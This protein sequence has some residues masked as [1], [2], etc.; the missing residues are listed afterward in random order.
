[1][2]PLTTVPPLW[3]T[4]EGPKTQTTVSRV[5]KT[6]KL[7]KTLVSAGTTKWGSASTG[8][9]EKAR[10]APVHTPTRKSAPGS[11]LADQLHW[12]ADGRDAKRCTQSPARPGKRAQPALMQTVK[13]ST[14]WSQVT[15]ESS[16][17]KEPR[18]MA[19]PK[20]P[21]PTPGWPK[22]HHNNNQLLQ[23][24]SFLQLPLHPSQQLSSSSR[25]RGLED[26]TCRLF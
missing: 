11:H 13:G 4:N 1:M 2:S 21:G 22:G 18:G 6:K 9:A 16:Q 20:I 14:Q 15:K 19:G 8:I 24:D 26:L 3:T 25:H 7:Q 23:K 5:Q 10:K 12:V 17:L